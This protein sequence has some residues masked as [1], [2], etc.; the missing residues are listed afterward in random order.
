MAG[1]ALWDAASALDRR[2]QVEEAVR[3]I[4]A[5]NPNNSAGKFGFLD[6][7]LA[8]GRAEEARAALAEIEKTLPSEAAFA[9]TCCPGHCVSRAR[10]SHFAQR[11]RMRP[12]IKPAHYFV[13]RQDIEGYNADIETRGAILMAYYFANLYSSKPAGQ[14]MLRDPRV[15]QM[16]VRY[17]FPAYWREKGWPAGCRP[18]GEM[19]FECGIDAAPV[20]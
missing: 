14:A 6:Y 3:R 19:D 7:A 5:I 2:D 10:P 18:L 20:H 9:E 4:R 12:G 13:A 8:H 15:K 17:G 11:S 1:Y 16:L